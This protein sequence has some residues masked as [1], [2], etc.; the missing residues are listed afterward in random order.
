MNS[1]NIFL[2]IG[3]FGNQI[4][5]N[6]VEFLTSMKGVD[7]AQKDCSFISVDTEQKAA[8]MFFTRSANVIVENCILDKTGR[9]ANWAMGYT[10]HRERE[11]SLPQKDIVLKSIK[12]KIE[13]LHD[14]LPG[15]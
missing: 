2:F 15:W 14:R 10:C 4:G 13:K 9:G 7:L 1:G 5:K 12:R 11:C 8:K 6:L 3:Q